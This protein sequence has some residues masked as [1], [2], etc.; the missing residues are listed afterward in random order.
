MIFTNQRS[1][2]PNNTTIIRIPRNPTP[3][4]QP[5]QITETDIP[6]KKK[7]IWGEPTWFLFHTLAEKV[8]AEDFSKIRVELLNII[9]TICVNLPCPDC[10]KHATDYM[11]KINYSTIQTK[12]QLKDM[13]FI[14]HN[15]VNK[16]KFVTLFRREDLESKYSLA[17]TIPVIQNFMTRFRNKHASIHMIANDLHRTR[18]SN[19]MSEWFNKN[20]KYFDL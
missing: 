18:I 2:R 19:I 20:I 13:L 7:M 5:P 1:I 6:K 15:E 4:I 11:N 12:E 10:A 14:F 9:Y 8:H 17:N 3:T 16:R